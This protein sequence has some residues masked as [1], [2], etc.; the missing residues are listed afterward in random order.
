MLLY[1]SLC[2][3]LIFHS[4]V[5]AC[6]VAVSQVVTIPG[7]LFVRSA[8]LLLP[9]VARRLPGCLPA[10]LS[11]AVLFVPVGFAPSFLLFLGA[12]LPS[13]LF[14]AESCRPCEFFNRTPVAR[15][16]PAI[17]YSQ[18]EGLGSFFSFRI[19]QYWHSL[20]NQWPYTAVSCLLL[21]CSFYQNQAMLDWLPG[22]LCAV[23]SQGY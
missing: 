20:A 10:G 15:S 7:P 16:W 2:G 6:A 8:R 12:R 1:P 3:M 13:Y 19:S 5:Y 23:V 22:L 14:N 4:G 21:S 9:P 11:P 17:R 18:N